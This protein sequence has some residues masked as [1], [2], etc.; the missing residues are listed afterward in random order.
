M[1]RRMKW[2]EHAACMGEI[3][4][5]YKILNFGGENV[6]ERQH[7]EDQGK[8]NISMDVTEIGWELVD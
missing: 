3:R 5:A 2:V 6:K 4:N 8:Y 1:L 7:L